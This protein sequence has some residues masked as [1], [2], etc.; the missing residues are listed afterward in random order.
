MY[1]K[2]LKKEKSK[3]GIGVFA[4]TKIPSN[5]P[6]LEF[7]GE[8]FNSK[9]LKHEY[10][11]FVQIGPDLFMG[12]SGDIDDFINHSCNP[13]CYLHIVGARAILYS[14]YVIAPES[15]LTFDYSTTDTLD[16]WKM[17]CRC[18]D[19]NCRNTVTGFNSL[20]ED[21]KADLEDKG[22]LPLYITNQMFKR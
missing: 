3:N 15:E 22:I 13:N 1:S 16:K 4:T 6:I 21:V 19:I 11:Q 7:K 17:D 9:S 14:L 10:S 2:F 5:V 8:L 18:G 20:K 12:P